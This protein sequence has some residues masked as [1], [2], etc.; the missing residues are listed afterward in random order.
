MRFCNLLADVVAH[1]CV[2]FAPQVK[3]AILGLHDR[4]LLER[5]RAFIACLAYYC[6][7]CTIMCLRVPICSYLRFVH[8]PVAGITS[9][10]ITSGYAW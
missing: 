7:R 3:M 6:I 8:L 1:C 10:I 2:H 9:A 5:L 4:L